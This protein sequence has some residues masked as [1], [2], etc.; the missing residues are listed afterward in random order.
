MIGGRSTSVLTALGASMASGIT[1][2]ALF[3]DAVY[4]HGYAAPKLRNIVPG[5]W[6]KQNPNPEKNK[7]RF[8]KRKHGA[9]QCRIAI[10]YWKAR[11]TGN[12]DHKYIKKGPIHA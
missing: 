6:R 12:L 3:G 5:T 4:S 8:L 1:V 9:R 10:K 7:V 2:A 11:E